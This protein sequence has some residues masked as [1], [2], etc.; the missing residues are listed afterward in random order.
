MMEPM[1]VGLP[2]VWRCEA[3]ELPDGIEEVEARDQLQRSMEPD[4]MEWIQY[5][6]PKQSNGQRSFYPDSGGLFTEDPELREMMAKAIA[7]DYLGNV[8]KRRAGEVESLAEAK[9][10][11]EAED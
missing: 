10:K 7:D 2:Y 4:L 8:E 11:F 3:R 5:E 1:P 9:R 6:R